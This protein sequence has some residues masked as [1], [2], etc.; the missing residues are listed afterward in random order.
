MSLTKKGQVTVPSRALPEEQTEHLTLTELYAYLTET[1]V[2]SS[3]ARP[4]TDTD[5]HR[6][7]AS[8]VKEHNRPL[9]ISL[10]VWTTNTV[11]LPQP[12]NTDTKRRSSSPGNTPDPQNQ[13]RKA[14]Q[15]HGDKR[16][17]SPQTTKSPQTL[18]N[19]HEAEV[20]VQRKP[21]QTS[22]SGSAG[23]PDQCGRLNRMQ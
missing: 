16:E 10:A 20:I 1:G 21:N 19:R 6:S 9:E 22:K 4:G 11:R 3:P 15:S 17:P 2:E 13:T 14:G 7:Q 23:R 5:G 18:G 12:S 8:G